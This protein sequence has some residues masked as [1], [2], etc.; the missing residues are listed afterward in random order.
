MPFVID[1]VLDISFFT[2]FY[3]GGFDEDEGIHPSV[4]LVISPHSFDFVLNNDEQLKFIIHLKIVHLKL[5]GL[6]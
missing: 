6:A 4:L 3:M 5:Y 2:L 1:E